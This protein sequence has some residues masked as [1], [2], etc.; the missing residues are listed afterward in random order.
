MDDWKGSIVGNDPLNLDES[1]EWAG[2]WW[3]PDDPGYQ[4]PGVLRYEPEDGLVLSLIGTFEDRFMTTPSPG[5]EMVHEGSRTWD[6]I[7]GAAEQ[8]EITLLG[9]V[10]KSTKRT[11]GARVKSPDKQSVVVT[12]A[13]IGVHIGSEDEA[14]FSMVEVSVENFGLW[15]ATSVF[16]QVLSVSDGRPD[17]RGSISV[18]P[19]EEQSV[20]VDG[21]KFVL[22]H[23]HTLPFFDERQGGTVGRMRDTA[24]MQIVPHEATSLHG[25]MRSAHLIQDLIT[26][27]IHRAAGVIWLR[28]KLAGDASS[29]SASG[30]PRL[31]RKVE[32]IYSPTVTGESDAKEIDHRRVFFTCESLP[33]E[34][35]IRRWC[36]MHERFQPA[37]NMVLGLRYAPGRYVENNL[38]TAAG[39][40]EV[41]HRG[42]GIGGPPI[43]PAD[44]KSM[45]KAMLT[46]VPEEH[47]DRV[48]E[49]LRNDRTLRERLYDLA[50]RPDQEAVSSLVPD[51][52]RW[53][54]RTTTARND[55]THK[56]QTRDYSIDELIAVVDV[57][58]AVVILNLLNELGLPAERQREIVHD[59]PQLRFTASKARDW[60]R[61]P[62]ADS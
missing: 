5:L 15:A 1:G 61:T 21:T 54:G 13:L 62:E 28:L 12:T 17:G 37:I 30:R 43:P 25:A 60:L 49:S 16:E 18:K 47:Q 14:A 35:V 50:A 20:E 10:P 22:A 42:L 8:R 29:E 48:R 3:L 46:H 11:I 51:V 19:L 33:F 45:R 31:E 34:V 9:C 59:H 53:A 2:L 44:F 4:V 26:L 52:D 23:R 36:E 41:L 6:V 39:A 38:L 55:L 40:A 32:V 58:T 57:T 7:Q 27:A 24:Y 56:G